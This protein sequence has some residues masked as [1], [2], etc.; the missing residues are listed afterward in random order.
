MVSGARL[1]KL[2]SSDAQPSTFEAIK[3]IFEIPESMVS[4]LKVL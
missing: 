3:S 2:T 1:V 4:R